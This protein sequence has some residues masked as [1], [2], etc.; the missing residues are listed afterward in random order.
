MKSLDSKVS[1]PIVLFLPPDISLAM[2]FV[3]P[4]SPPSEVTYKAVCHR[5]INGEIL[6]PS[7]DDACLQCFGKAA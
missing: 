4:Q 5:G 6:Q 2:A 3:F 7:L 1:T